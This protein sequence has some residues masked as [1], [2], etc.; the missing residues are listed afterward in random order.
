MRCPIGY[1]LAVILAALFFSAGIDAA[2][3]TDK[4]VITEK[5][6]RQVT[7]ENGE[8]GLFY[9][10]RVN[11]IPY[12]EFLRDEAYLKAFKAELREFGRFK[13]EE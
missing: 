3:F 1:F 7:L 8:R 9:E 4:A 11:G 12:E 10:Y 13:G 6:V 5:S 2:H